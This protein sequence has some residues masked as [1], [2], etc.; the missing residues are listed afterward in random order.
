MPVLGLIVTLALPGRVA[1]AD[2]PAPVDPATLARIRDA[3]MTSDWAFQRLTDLADTIGP[4]LS[5]SAGAAAAV[6][7]VAESLR[8]TGLQVRL[9]PVKVPHWVRGEERGELVDYAGG[10]RASRSA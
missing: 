8:G 4:R 2:P 10:R 1:A 5:G 7:Q 3:A 9:Q 6:A